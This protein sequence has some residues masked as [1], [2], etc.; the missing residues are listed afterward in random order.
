MPLEIPESPPRA[1]APA[2]PADRPA[3]AG[4]AAPRTPPGHR[5]VAANPLAKA[6][7]WA[8]LPALLLTPALLWLSRGYEGQL[9]D[10]ERVRVQRTLE[11]HAGAVQR[12]V[13][14]IEGKLESLALFVSGQIAGDREI[15]DGQF[16]TFAAGL[17]A[18]STWIRAFEVVRG[19]IITQVYP[20]A[21]NETVR[22]YNLLTDA[23]P[24]IGGDVVRAEKTGRI[25]MTGPI[26]LL[27]GGL[28]VIIR[29]PLPRTSAAPAR[30]VAVVLNIEPLLAEAGLRPE[31]AGE[32]QFALRGGAGGVFFGSPAVFAGRPVTRRLVL[33]DGAWEIGARPRAGWQASMGGAVLRFRLTGATMIGLL[34][35][36]IFMLGYGRANLARI[37]RER[38]DDLRRELAARREAQELLQRNF[39][40]IEAVTE[41]TDDTVFAKDRQGR[42][43]MMNS[44]GARF[45]GRNR[46]DIIGRTDADL[47]A[48]ETATA[49]MADDRRVMESGRVQTIEEPLTAGGV[50]RFMQATKAAW[51]D[52]R[53]AVVGVVGI[54]RDITELKRA[55]QTLRA[56]EATLRGVFGAAP[57]GLG[58]LE[59][60]IHRTVNAWWCEK[61]G[62][63]EAELV[64]RSTRIL[65]E[66]DEEFERVGRALYAAGRAGIASVESRMRGRDGTVHDVVLT[67]APVRPGDPAAGTV[68]IIHDITERKQAERAIRELN[69][70]LEQRVAARTAELAV[71]RDRAE[72]ADRLKSAFLATMS[73]ELRTPLNSIIGFTGIILQGLA[74]PLS[75]EQ[76]RQL[77]MV[78]GSAR[79]LLSLIN[80]VLDISK[81]EAGQLQVSRAPFDLRA[82]IDKVVGIVRPLAEKKGLALV[83]ELAPG[84]GPAVNDERRVEQVLLNLLNNAVKFTEQGEVRLTAI[85]G[86]DHSVVLAVRDTG[87]GIKPEDL[88]TLFQPFRQ[89]DTGLSRQHE[90]TGLGLA[91]CRRLADLM[92]GRI[93][94]ASEWGRGSVFT[95]TLPI[96]D[97]PGGPPAAVPP[98]DAQP[99]P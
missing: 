46:A 3:G 1:A 36:V 39:A 51:R 22:G 41:G 5:G 94:A 81:I 98:G 76:S 97:A 40:L 64:G 79:H 59:N 31:D 99:L 62:Y 2:S 69:A 80:D 7:L 11:L 17:H 25:T 29:R 35:L 32:V 75:G 70:S 67:A 6:V 58:I 65:Y 83:V 63:T 47:F 72:E 27:Q 74:G 44:A 68:A 43:Q 20:L 30:L 42:Y 95:V 45:L 14:R 88:A 16:A 85:L 96:D 73:H 15:D 38:T 8:A 56:S 53:G 4:P 23:R 89:I 61:F 21:G 93:E 84:I 33:P 71:A 66:T 91:I 92:G 26:D 52:E 82:S 13:D 24:P 90:G 10:E 37:V 34:C 57:V 86:R 9:A 77:E 55:E 49:I 19:G 50:T 28:G 48:A 78:R 54:A 87:I 12:S 60:R 18:S